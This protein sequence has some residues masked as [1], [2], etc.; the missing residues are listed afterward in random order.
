MIARTIWA[1][2]TAGGVLSGIG[3][4]GIAGVM[5]WEVV[6][7]YLFNAPTSWALEVVSYLLVASASLGSAYTLRHNGHVAV[8]VVVQM[9]P[10]IVQ[11]VLR[12]L[13]HAAIAAFALVLIVYGAE[14][15][16]HAYRLGEISLTPLAMKMWIPSA[17]VPLGGLLLLLQALEL[18]V[19]PGIREAGHATTID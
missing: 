17:V 16:R 8:D 9:C 18:I 3:I 14:Q 15:V 5:T 10:P 2:V 12:A 1:L 7:R 13:T 4:L 6:A 11:R 19:N